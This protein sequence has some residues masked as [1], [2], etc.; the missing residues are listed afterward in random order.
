MTNY[1]VA[2]HL[3]LTGGMAEALAVI[4]SRMAGLHSHVARIHEGLLGWNKAL[5]AVGA[6]LGALAVEKTFMHI[7]NAATP[8][9]NA[10]DKLVRTGLAYNE[11]LKV[12]KSFFDD[13]SKRI[14]TASASDF[15][16]IV[17]ELRPIF[18]KDVPIEEVMKAAEKATMVDTLLANITGRH[19][20]KGELGEYYKL[21]RATEMKGVATDPAKRELFTDEA[22]KYITAFGGKLKADDYQTM[23][24][25]GG[26]AWMHTDIGKT[27]GPLSVLAAELGGSGA[28]QALMSLFQF[29]QGVATLSR[30]QLSMMAQ[31]GLLDMSKVHRSGMRW[32]LDPLAVTGAK[33]YGQDLPGWVKNIVAP[34]AHAEAQRRAA[35]GEGT[36]EALFENIMMRMMPN[37]NVAKLGMMFSD[38]GFLDQIMKDMGLAEMV[39][40]VKEAYARYISKNPEGVKQA[41]SKQWESM[42]EAIGVP[43]MERAMPIMQSLTEVFRQA[44][45][46]ANS[47]PEAIGRIADGLAAFG[48]ALASISVTMLAAWLGLPAIIL[49]VGTALLTLDENVR[50]A[51]GG[52]KDAIGHGDANQIIDAGLK[53]SGAV[54]AAMV[55]GLDAAVAAI[56]PTVR[57]I[58]DRLSA[59]V[60]EA[61]GNIGSSVNRLFHPTDAWIRDH[62]YFKNKVP[63]PE[64]PGLG[65]GTP[66]PMITTPPGMDQKALF[67]PGGGGS[68]ALLPAAAS[69]IPSGGGAKTVQVHNVIYLD[70]QAIARSINDY[71]IAGMEH[72]TQ[73]PYF[74]GRAGYTSPDHQPITA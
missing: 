56:T 53:L 17:K 24:R 41:F 13:I 20:G 34:A 26:V 72:P 6:G 51:W 30:Q 48:I 7:A 58:W 33:E 2:V 28:G 60:L 27:M 74:D 64:V 73:A 32:S 16:G 19:V 14:P 49:S 40:A 31:M 22:F 59:A 66:P 44:G 54:V 70:G 67:M 65:W 43:F 69:A 57:A 62:P 42:W 4:T 25:R 47:N 11:V 10:Q 36:E 68:P 12:Q 39:P 15:M 63:A 35:K 46:W 45:S 37:R 23:A 61:M 50:K 9:L 1:D 18:G 8:L 21:L 38:P 29:Q 3:S 71:N 55:Q 52:L 5:I